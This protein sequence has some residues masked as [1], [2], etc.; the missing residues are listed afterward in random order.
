MINENIKPSPM[1]NSVE[2][3]SELY[4]GSAEMFPSLQTTFPVTFTSVTAENLPAVSGG[5]K[6]H[7]ALG[8]LF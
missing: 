2:A 7:S 1:W 4:E 3:A 6:L 5:A 8:K